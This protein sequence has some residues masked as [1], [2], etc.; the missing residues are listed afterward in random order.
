MEQLQTSFAAP[1]SPEVFMKSDLT[2]AIRQRMRM[3]Y[4]LRRVP[5]KSFST[6][7]P[8]S[9][10][11]SPGDVALAQLERIGRNAN[12]ELSNGRRCSLHE[13]DLLAVAFGNRY[14]TMQFEGYARLDE[15]RCDLLT[16]GGVCGLVESKHAKAP[17][18]SKLRLI[19]FLGDSDERPLRLRN[20]ALAARPAASQPHIVV[21][22]GTSM[23][24]GKTHTALSLIMGLRRQGF[25]V[26]AIKLTGTATG[27]DIWN[28][29]DAGA[30]EAFDFVDGG[31]PST[32]LCSAEELVD[33]YHLLVA[34][35]SSRLPD[36]VVVEI[37][38]GLFQNETSSL[39]QHRHFTQNVAAWIFAAGDPLG[40]AGGVRVLRTWGIEPLAVSGIVSMSA[41]GIQET[42][43]ATQLPCLT[44]R[45]LQCGELNPHL[46][47]V[48]STSTTSLSA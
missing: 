43:K 14:A 22:C 10:H 46:L 16:M 2:A 11:P 21:V 24:S 42:Q 36:F 37:A 5:E 33:L 6:L 32:Y 28:M 35:A 38:D 48:K 27:K 25:E 15:D 47:A 26:A 29:L 17:D 19:G 39:L 31:F 8:L 9:S 41:L 45:S 23:D 4:V 40:A 34:R 1:P 20:F 30:C 12:L 3:P 7:L 13:G 18:P 44:A